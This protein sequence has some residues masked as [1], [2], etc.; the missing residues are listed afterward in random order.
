MLA[1]TR[2]TMFASLFA[3]SIATTLAV[4][5][6]AD[7]NVKVVESYVAAWNAHDS[8]AAAAFFADDV[9]YLDASVGTP[10]VGR[11]VARQNVIEAF[12][13]AVP[14]AKWV[15]IGEPVAAGDSVS[16]EWEF[17]GTNTGDWSDGTKAT[18]KPFAIK[19][20]SMF[21]LKDGKIAYQADYYDALGFYKQLGLM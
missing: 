5:V 7:D 20:V 11:D 14:D 8:N 17:S 3:F 15:A 13:T 9:E 21:R 18:G 6:Y 19:G 2:R 1:L 16:F 12:L 10:Q 4:P